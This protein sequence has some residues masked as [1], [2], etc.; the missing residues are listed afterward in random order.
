MP[1]IIKIAYKKDIP[2]I[3]EY[4][5]NYWSENHIFVKNKSYLFRNTLMMIHK[6]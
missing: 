1:D 2:K 3:Q 4:L 5:K 6:N